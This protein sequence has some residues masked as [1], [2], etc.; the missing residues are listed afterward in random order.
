M[1]TSLQ[2]I[3]NDVVSLWTFLFLFGAA[4]G[5][6]TKSLE[7]MVSMKSTELWSYGAQKKKSFPAPDILATC[8]TSFF[9]GRPLAPSFL[10]DFSLIWTTTTLCTLGWKHGFCHYFASIS[11]LSPDFKCFIFPVTS[12]Q[13][14]ENSCLSVNILLIQWQIKECQSSW[15][16]SRL[17]TELP[18]GRKIPLP[19]R[20]RRAASFPRSKFSL[21]KRRGRALQKKMSYQTYCEFPASKCTTK[22]Q[23]KIAATGALFT[24]SNKAWRWWMQNLWLLGNDYAV[25]FS[26]MLHVGKSIWQMK[27]PLEP[28]SSLPPS[29]DS[30]FSLLNPPTKSYIM[31]PRDLEGCCCP[32]SQIW[33]FLSYS[34]P[35]ATPF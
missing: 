18:W 25:F 8:H 35:L 13:C 33:S 24:L 10:F 31:A 4:A 22:A 2:E 15:F 7:G 9:P 1:R 26:V 29:R 6:S 17:K 32:L 27:A 12:P 28:I 19:I 20:P 23:T 11:S 16:H 21:P 30:F 3:S 34:K 5:I 14:W